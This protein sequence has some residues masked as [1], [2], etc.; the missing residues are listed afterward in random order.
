MRRARAVLTAALSGSLGLAVLATAAPSVPVLA[1]ARSSVSTAFSQSPAAGVSADDKAKK[2]ALDAQ[3]SALRDQLDES[4][5]ALQDAAVALAQ[6]Q[7]ELPDAQAAA[8][9]AS[10]ALDKAKAH[11][12]AVAAQLQLA[13]AEQDKG[14]R[15]LAT[16]TDRLAQQQS[17]LGEL[18]AA[19]YRSGGMGELAVALNATSPDQ[20]ADRLQLVKAALDAGDAALADLATSK[21]DLRAAQAYLDAKQAQVAQMRKESQQAVAERQRRADEATAAQAKVE[22]LIAA[23]AAAKQTIEEQRR[24]EQEQLRQAEQQ[25]AALAARIKKAEEQAARQ[26]AV[27]A[28]VPSGA[29]QFP[30]N[31]RISTVAGYR[32]N[33]VTGNPSCHSGIDIAPGG[34]AP[35]YAAAAGVVIAT[36]YTAWDGYTTV[37]AHGGGLATWYAHQPGFSVSVGQQVQRGQVIGYVGASGFATG[38]HLHFNV[39]V[40]GVAYDPMGWFGGPMRTVA[41]LCPNG[42]AVVL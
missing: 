24:L 9:S 10:A 29:L 26:H 16:A 30:A 7:S 17:D 1:A 32:T 22:Q 25:S 21:A 8:A 19:A 28:G 12:E 36:E 41:S 33:P 38:P 14:K 2:K 13:E 15:A 4:S 18:A 35:I 31:G 5:Q 3:I 37:I 34:G 39:T 6:A 11:D 23:R 40:N 42:P 20:F 27:P